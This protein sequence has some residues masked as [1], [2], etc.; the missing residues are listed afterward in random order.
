MEDHNDENVGGENIDMQT[1]PSYHDFSSY[2]MT[3]KVYF[4]RLIFVCVLC[5]VTE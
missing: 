1:Q 3:D 5:F 2:F 4:N